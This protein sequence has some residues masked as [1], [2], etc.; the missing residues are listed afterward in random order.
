[1]DAED[2]LERL[3]APARD[4]L[5]AAQDTLEDTRENTS[6]GRLYLVGGAP[7]DLLLGTTDAAFADLDLSL[8]GG[9]AGELAGAL[10]R[11]LGGKLTRYPAFGSATLELPDA[12]VL[13]LV[14]TRAERYERPGALPEV[15][16][17]TLHDDLERRD[18]SVN[19]LALPLAPPVTGSLTGLRT[20]LRTGP[21]E[22]GSRTLLDPFGGLNDL[23]ARHLRILHPASFRDDPTR[24]LR[25]ARLAARLGFAFEPGTRR[26]LEETL[27]DPPKGLES[28]LRA[29]LERTLQEER[30]ARALE[31]LDETGALGALFGLALEPGVARALEAQAAPPE[32]YLLALLLASPAARQR[33]VARFGWPR[34]TLAQLS[35]LEAVRAAGTLPP[36]QVARLGGAERALLRALSPTLAAQLAALDAGRI[37]AQDVIDLGLP[38]GHALGEVLAAVAVARRDRQLATL[39]QELELARRLVRERLERQEPT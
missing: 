1:M 6:A 5:A 37:R 21:L 14:S 30:P 12:F 7:R 3:P 18:F 33:A 23:A 17:G 13:D 26:A 34:R 4:L 39:E 27:A 2:L 15:R 32:S 22:R 38:P 28:R 24:I 36:E 20:G 11:R 31:L 35:R 8:E 19:A 9:D 25:G 16:P 29:E 10:E